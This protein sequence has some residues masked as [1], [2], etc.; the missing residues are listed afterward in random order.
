MWQLSHQNP[1]IGQMW[2]HIPNG[3]VLPSDNRVPEPIKNICPSVAGA[4]SQVRPL[5]R[6]SWIDLS[7]WGRLTNEMNSLAGLTLGLGAV[8]LGGC[9]SSHKTAS[10]TPT[11]AIVTPDDAQRAT[12]AMYNPIGRFVVLNFPAGSLPKHDQVFFIYHGG[13]NAGE[14]KITGPERDNSTVAD[15]I[16]GEAHTGDEV[17][18]Q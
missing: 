15:L 18:D 14:V 1:L 9:A 12:V 3:L 6:E 2:V 17:R 4:D 7:K 5:G 10:A 8:L 11:P 16:T 13:L